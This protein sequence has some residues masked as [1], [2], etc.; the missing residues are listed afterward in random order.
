MI[1][2]Y[3]YLL[4]ILRLIKGLRMLRSYV[5]ILRRKGSCP[6]LDLLL[7]LGTRPT[8]AHGAKAIIRIKERLEREGCYNKLFSIYASIFL[9]T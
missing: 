1:K 2:S 9:F 5:D 8:T 3:Y 7:Y 6:D 4:A